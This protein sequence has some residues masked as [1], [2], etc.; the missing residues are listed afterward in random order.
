[1]KA[2]ELTDIVVVV[3]YGSRSTDH[4]MRH[5]KLL[6]SRPL[7]HI[8]HHCMSLRPWLEWCQLQHPARVT[9]NVQGRVL[10][11]TSQ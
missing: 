6:G 7:Y 4:L 8:A 11:L 1:M 9:V 2:W 10:Q 5:G 3:V